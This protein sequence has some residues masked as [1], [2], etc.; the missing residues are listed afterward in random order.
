MKKLIPVIALMTACAPS[1][2]K[3]EAEKYFVDM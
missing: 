1:E 2:E 3:F